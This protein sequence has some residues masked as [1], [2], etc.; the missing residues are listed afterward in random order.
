M[1][2]GQ[3]VY[4]SPAA[5]A[6]FGVGWPEAE[7]LNVRSFWASLH[8][9]ARFI[10]DLERLGEVA[11]WETTARRA[12]GSTFP[13]ALTARLLE[14][15]GRRRIVTSLVDLTERQAREAAMR[16]ARGNAG[17]RDRLAER[18]LCAVRRGRPAG[19]VQRAVSGVQRQAG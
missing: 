7:T 10:A 18:G 2:S 14:H 12:D 17:G 5:A 19:G 9:R 3:I 4:A 11:N 8:D 13:I 1:E 15:D 16:E 6:L